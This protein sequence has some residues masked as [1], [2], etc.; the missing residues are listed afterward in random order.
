MPTTIIDYSKEIINF[1]DNVNYGM[2]KPQL[3]HLATIIEGN[4]NLEGKISISKI[5]KNIVKAK[6][7]SCICRFLSDSPWDD[8]LLNHNRLGYLQH[9]MDRDLSS[10]DIGF[11]VIDDTVNLKDLRTKSMEGLD[12]HYSHVKGKACWSHCIVN[13]HF[14]AGSYSVPIQ[15]KPYYREEKCS[16]FSVSFQSKT[17]IAQE[18]IQTFE[19]PSELKNIYVLVDSWYTSTNL[20]SQTLSQ[21]YHLIGGMK[22]N[23]IFYPDGIRTKISEF[24]EALDPTNLDSVTVKDKEYKVFR[25]E[26]KIIKSD[27]IILL[28]S[29]EVKKDG[30]E[31]PVCIISTDTSLDTKTILDYYSVRWTIETSYQ[32]LKESLGFDQYKVRSLVAIERYISLCFL[33][34]TFLEIFR[35][36]KGNLSLK[37]IGEVIRHHKNVT[38]KKFISYIYYQAKQNIPLKSL[39]ESLKLPA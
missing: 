32:Y 36:S 17:D 34:Y 9:I 22:R 21:G 18:L 5:A 27:N 30:F 24:I 1:L 29:Y 13:S 26:G 14:V 25:Y 6:D 10:E 31:N 38:V 19:K 37:T 15:F 16:E 35:V 7:Q 23:R 39:Y 12:F 2:S 20:I 11:L 33:A 4:I 28:I 8:K 3:N